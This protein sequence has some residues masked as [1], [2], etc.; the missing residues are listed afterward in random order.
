M[1]KNANGYQARPDGTDHQADEDARYPATFREAQYETA[2]TCKCC[3]PAKD[4]QVE[5]SEVQE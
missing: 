5:G 1:L 4:D 2:G 3:D